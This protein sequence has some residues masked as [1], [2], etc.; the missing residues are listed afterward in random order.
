M[1]MH[2][3]FVQLLLCHLLLNLGLL[4][5]LLQSSSVN[6]APLGALDIF[7]LLDVVVDH[8]HGAFQLLRQFLLIALS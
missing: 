4:V 5:G 7:D 8:L 3:V 6:L 1:N 2:F